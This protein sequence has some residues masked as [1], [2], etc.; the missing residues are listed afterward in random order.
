VE[1]R[2]ES[3]LEQGRRERRTAEEEEE[4]EGRIEVA[5]GRP[6]ERERREMRRVNMIEFFSRREARKSTKRGG[7]TTKEGVDVKRQSKSKCWTELPLSS[8]LTRSEVGFDHHPRTEG[9]MYLA[10]VSLGLIQF[11]P[12]HHPKIGDELALSF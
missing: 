9:P 6:D 2:E 12:G 11:G 4:V 10:F 3:D 5:V 7:K 1:A 8:F